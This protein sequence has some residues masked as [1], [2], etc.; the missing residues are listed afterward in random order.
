VIDWRALLAVTS[1]ELRRTR[2]LVRYW[3]FVLLALVVPTA[4]FLYHGLLAHR[5]G[6]TIASS[7]AMINPRFF[8]SNYGLTFLLVYLLGV[9]FLGFDV[10]SRDVRAG[11]AEVLDARPIGN[12]ELLGGRMLGLVVASWLPILGMV[13]LLQ[14]VGLAIGVTME[15]SSLLVLLTLEA[16]PALAQV[17]A[18]V[19]LV[20]V[21]VRNR[22]VAA[23]ILLALWA[24]GFSTISGWIPLTLAQAPLLDVTG[25]TVV[26]FPSDLT[27]GLPDAAAW[28]HRLGALVAG[29][30]LLALAAALH[31]RRDGGSNRLRVAAGV[32]GLIVAAGLVA[33]P[34]LRNM[35]VLE[36]FQGYQRAQ[37][38]KAG[39]VPL[40]LQRIAGD[41]GIVPGRELRLDLE[42][43]LQALGEEPVSRLA[44]S[45]NPGL[46][47]EG[48]AAGGE[49][50]SATFEDG[51]IEARLPTPLAPG[52]DPLVL[53]LR[54]AG[55]PDGAFAYLDSSR[56][57]LE[58]QISSGMIFLFGFEP[59]FFE[60]GYV[61]LM[62]GAHWLP[63]VGSV[64]VEEGV[65]RVED[66]YELELAVEVPEGWSVAGPGRPR[67]AGDGR[68][69]RFVPGAPV[70]RT[71]LVA[72]RLEAL[73]AEAQGVALRLLV[74]E[75]HAGNLEPLR[76]AS[77]EVVSRIEQTLEDAASIGLP[78]PYDGMT[79]VEVPNALR[80]YA[81]GWREDT[82][83]AQPGMIL[84]R[85]SGLPTARWDVSFSE[86]FDPGPREGG[87]G[88][89][90]ADRLDRFFA[91][92]VSG[93]DARACA[94]RSFFDFTLSWSGPEAPAVDFV[95]ENLAAWLLT[96]ERSYFSARMFEGEEAQETL[97]ELLPRFFSSGRR[98][99]GEALIEQITSRPAVWN[100]VAAAPLAELDT[101]EEPQQALD[102]LVLKGGALARS[103]SEAFGRQ[104]LGE[105]LGTLRERHGGRVVSRGDLERA[106]A[107][108]GLPIQRWLD[109][110][111]ER[112]ELPAFVV[113]RARVSRLADA[114]DG[115][116]R[117]Q[118]VV[119]L[120]ND[121]P[122]P[123]VF[124]LESAFHS[125]EGGSSRRST[126]PYV[127]DG[128]EEVEIGLVH[129]EPARQIHVK[130]YLA[131][132]RQP[133]FV[134]PLTEEGRED[135]QPW[136]GLHEK[137]YGVPETGAVIADDLDPGFEASSPPQA[138]W[139]RIRGAEVDER[140]LDGGLPVQSLGRA[141]SR[142]T[143]IAASG[144]WG[145][146]RHTAAVIETD[147]R[148]ASASFSGDLPE[149]GSWYLELHRP[150]G[151]EEH[152]F[153]Y[154]RVS[155]A[156]VEVVVK[157][158][159]ETRE[160]AWDA[161]AAP[162]GWARVARFDMP[163][164]RF[165]VGL[166]LRGEEEGLIAADA[167]RWVPAHGPESRPTGADEESR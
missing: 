105:L 51:L 52:D 94:A 71:A 14:L 5:F 148:E 15:G 142:W 29:F 167:V 73:E 88:A 166:S 137:T 81:G 50:L 27:S 156:E 54:A 110:W 93:G 128:R 72:S 26:P 112:V 7:F 152:I 70:S 31:P 16:I 151:L 37:L 130:P 104:E 111:L 95:T 138:G 150:A 98:N 132:N 116:P 34:F 83:L 84:V 106:A 58:M 120:R 32:A 53:R 59:L 42:L 97:G 122:V 1:A 25:W 18:V 86:D 117:Y 102:A 63:S 157:A 55:L 68:T 11:V 162:F 118:H 23:L 114:E 10:R 38:E 28:L 79:M 134:E 12:L 74:G 108:L 115:T 76:P 47:L 75:A 165:R 147:D 3:V 113:E 92:D 82:T 140:Q 141:P 41:V 13:V 67:A 146:Y 149:A 9:I 159:G 121:G 135:A 89:A 96:R 20:T 43:T 136:T 145:R 40:D 87:V 21:L 119:R 24:V 90:I 160:A 22:L 35:A 109:V 57:V 124:V 17:I 126:E 45:L 6:S 48:L 66:A 30:A 133:F 77:T 49:D 123:G 125:E 155:W 131:E 80:G 158:G 39:P 46:E 91:G 143:R 60:R 78:Y 153:G 127:I 129:R 19:F 144:A 62:P 56:H 2:R 163:A 103:M 139:A 69:V 36:R 164:G 100:A 8:T 4:S 44:L 33:A 64:L 161:E 107:D 65:A 99:L 85:E 61:A 101:R 154:G